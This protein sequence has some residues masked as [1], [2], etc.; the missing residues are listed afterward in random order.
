MTVPTWH[1]V[2]SED[3]HSI[4]IKSSES[5]VGA[6][7]TPMREAHR[8]PHSTWMSL[9]CEQSWRATHA[10]IGRLHLCRRGIAPARGSDPTV[11]KF[12]HVLS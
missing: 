6:Y 3:G 2:G 8:H 4:R 5:A 10:V 12:R 9:D 1:G 7:N 11:H